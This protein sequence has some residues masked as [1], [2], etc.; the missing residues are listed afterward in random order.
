MLW[1]I[2]VWHPLFL[3]SVSL[4]LI[5][6]YF[7]PTIILEVRV[8]RNI[9]GLV[10]LN[11]FAGWTIVGWII[12]LVWALRAKKYRAG[13]SIKDIERFDSHTDDPTRSI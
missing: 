11:L 5:S 6:V 3:I 12:A 1:Q 2:I 10:L 13:L 4:L 8:Q 7:A 9:V